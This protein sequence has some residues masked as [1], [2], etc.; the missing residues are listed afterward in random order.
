[1][2]HPLL[3]PAH[4]CTD[5]DASGG[6]P[7]ADS[8]PYAWMPARRECRRLLLRAGHFAGWPTQIERVD[9]LRTAIED[10]DECER[11]VYVAQAVV[12]LR[13]RGMGE[14]RVSVRAEM[15]ADGV[16]LEFGDRELETF[17]ALVQNRLREK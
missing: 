8:H 5:A 16:P 17:I 2:S 12:S 6:Y 13:L 3:V 14:R 9:A 10:P 11:F 7:G 1:M 4:S 15:M